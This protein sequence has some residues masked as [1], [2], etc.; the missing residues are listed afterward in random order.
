MKRL[1]LIGFAACAFA[2]MPS[3]SVSAL[4]M[5][6][7][8]Q[9]IAGTESSVILAK[10]GHGHGWGGAFGRPFGWSRGRKVGWRVRVALLVSG[11]KGA[12]K[13]DRCRL[14]CAGRSPD[15]IKVKN[16]SHPALDRIK[17]SF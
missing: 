8:D 5:A 9:L 6:P 3:F 4:P 16:R 7:A 1:L 17:E 14:Y 13:N 15:W 11:S 12:A 2:A 10:G